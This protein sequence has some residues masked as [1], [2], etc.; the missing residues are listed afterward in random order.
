MKKICMN[1]GGI[2]RD[3]ALNH[4]FEDNMFFVTVH[5]LITANPLHIVVSAIASKYGISKI[6][7][8]LVLVF[9]L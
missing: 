3:Y 6:V 5:T 4:L 7:V 8:A 1:L 9:L 2:C